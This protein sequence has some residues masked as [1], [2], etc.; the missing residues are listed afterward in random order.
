MPA[1][2][3][4]ATSDMPPCG[5]QGESERRIQV[6]NMAH[7]HHFPDPCQNIHALFLT[8]A[9]R[10]AAASPSAKTSS[11]TAHTLQSSLSNNIDPAMMTITSSLVL[12]SS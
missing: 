12:C 9:Q 7:V 1:I 4:V 6:R 2:I 5:Q 11:S 8:N 10:V 3:Q